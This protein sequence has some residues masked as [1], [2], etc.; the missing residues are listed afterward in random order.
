LPRRRLDEAPPLGVLGQGL[1]EQVLDV[2]P[3]V[4]RE[5]LDPVAPG[6]GEDRRQDRVPRDGLVLGEDL[7]LGD[8]L[9]Q[10]DLAGRRLCSRSVLWLGHDASLRPVAQILPLWSRAGTWL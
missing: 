8:L 5:P 1:L 9:Q 3:A 2:E 7:P 10:P 4:R 6:L